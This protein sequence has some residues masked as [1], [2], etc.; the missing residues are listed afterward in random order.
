M[1]KVFSRHAVFTAK[2][3]AECRFINGSLLPD[4]SS[5]VSRKEQYPGKFNNLYD[6][7]NDPTIFYDDSNRK[8]IYNL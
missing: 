7:L 6:R 5:N 2:T 3:M 4:L 8:K 1:K